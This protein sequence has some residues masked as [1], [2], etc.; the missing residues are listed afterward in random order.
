ME[1]KAYS[2]E[3]RREVLRKIQAGQKVTAVAAEY[4]IK[5]TTVRNWL[6]RDTGGRSGKLLEPS[7]LTRLSLF[8]L[9]NS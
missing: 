3:I 1:H 6:A 2:L 7:R 9:K 8:A 4:G 5:E